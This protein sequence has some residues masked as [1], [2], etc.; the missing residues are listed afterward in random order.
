[1]LVAVLPLALVPLAI[2]VV[3]DSKAI[4][5]VILEVAFVNLAICPK[6]HTLAML[7]AREPVSLVDPSI[8]PVE[9]PGALHLVLFEASLVDLAL[10]CDSS[11]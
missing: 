11:S 10:A 8:W 2:W 1:M 5:V 4:A 7:L 9:E 6:V 3:L